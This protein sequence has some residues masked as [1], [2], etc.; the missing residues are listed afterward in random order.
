VRCAI[1][2]AVNAFSFCHPISD[3]HLSPRRCAGW[4]GLLL[5]VAIGF[6]LRW[7]QI[8]ESLWLDEL[9]TSWVAGGGLHDVAQ[10]ARAGN[11][12]PLYFYLVWGLVSLWGQHEWVVRLPSVIAGVALIPATGWVTCRWTKSTWAALVATWLVALDRDCVFYAQEARPY[13]LL[14]LVALWH[15]FV[16]VNVLRHGRSRDR[17]LLVLGAVFLFYLHYTAFLFLAAELACWTMLTVRR[18]HALAYR[19][20]QLLLDL[21]VVGLFIVPAGPHLLRVA[22]RRANWTRLI[23]PWPSPALWYELVTYGL[24]PWLAILAARAFGGKRGGSRTAE[25][26]RVWIV[27]WWVVPLALAWLGTVTG[28]AALWMLRYVITALVGMI[29]FAARGIAC[30]RNRELR[31]VLTAVVCGACVVHGDM[32][33][34]WQI[35]GRVIGDRRED[36]ACAIQWLNH[37]NRCPV[38]PVF[39]VAGLLE[40][41]ELAHDPSPNLRAYCTFPLKGIYHVDTD[42]IEA[43]SSSGNARPSRH[44][45]QLAKQRRGCWLVVRAGP[46]GTQRRVDAMVRAFKQAGISIQVTGMRRFGGIGVLAFRVVPHV[47]VR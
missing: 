25:I 6:A 20:R 7:L 32:L 17:G 39:L 31:L 8:H 42:H 18:R 12:S 38:R 41:A 15:G 46:V 21:V 27:C 9:H 34:Q 29:V 16:F 23:G 35:D 10:R 28:L 24:I 33:R 4:A 19:P 44:E 2:V 40:D 13:A 11:Q 26:P 47:S 30:V 36:W 5:A 37:E 14:Q 1:I 45:I 43:L 3:S 22:A